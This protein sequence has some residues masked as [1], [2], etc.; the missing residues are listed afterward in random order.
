MTHPL[1]PAQAWQTMLE[2]NTRFVAGTPHHPHQ[3][4]QRR[5]DLAAGQRP[6]AT[7]FGCSD[8]RL[9]AEIIFDLGLGDLFVV[10]NAGQVPGE[11]II[12]SLEYAVYALEV[13]LLVVLA[14]DSC[15]AVAA[16]IDAVGENPPVLP[17]HIWRTISPIVPSVHAAA[18][19]QGPGQPIDPS[20]V[21]RL[22]LAETIDSILQ[23]S[24]MITEAVSGGALGIVGVSYRLSEGTV[25]PHV[26]KGAGMNAFPESAIR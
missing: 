11:S 23:S 22:H 24:E 7:L 17:T 8:S 21:G 15:G 13:P 6:L 3:D 25:V 16:A 12:G 20:L 26:I 1:T 19:Q 14:H 4:V 5:H 18:R 2:G 10:R 9:S